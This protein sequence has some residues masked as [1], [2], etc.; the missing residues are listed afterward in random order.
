MNIPILFE[1]DEVVVV[2][3]PS[4]LIVHPDARTQGD[5]LSDWF[6][7]HYP[8]AHYV[9]EL[10]H[11][12]SGEVI[13][14]FGIVHRLDRETSGVVILVKSQTSF[15]NIKSQFQNRTIEKMYNA[16]VFGHFKESEGEIDRPIGR[17]SKNF[18]L[19]S[20]Q[21][22][23][24]GTLREAV[25]LYKV[26]EQGR[27]TNTNESL[28]YMEVCPKTGRTHQIRV[29]MKA[30]NHQ[31]V[32]DLLYAPT[33]PFVL[34]FERLALHARSITFNLLDKKKVTVEAPLPFDFEH[35]LTSLRS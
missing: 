29:H 10:Q 35:A 30:I 26:L 13:E 8:E 3:K 27:D 32:G 1:N 9:G 22:G 31:I 7:R 2:N 24:K 6:I 23:A 17:S 21:R 12:P 18:R 28:S 34:G 11:T 25:T 16:F 4:G 15:L 5:S 33:R 19:W 20:A 14:R